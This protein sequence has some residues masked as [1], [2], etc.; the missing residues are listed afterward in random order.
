MFKNDPFWG[1]PRTPKWPVFDHFFSKIINSATENFQDPQKSWSFWGPP[2]MQKRPKPCQ[3]P[4]FAG[5]AR[6]LDPG[7][8]DD[9]PFWT[10]FW[11][12][13]ANTD[14][15]PHIIISNHQGEPLQYLIP[16]NTVTYLPK[17]LQKGVQ[18]W[19]K[20]RPKWPFF[21][22]KWITDYRTFSRISWK[23]GLRWCFPTWPDGSTPEIWPTKFA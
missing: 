4:F 18:K 17:G 20:N 3:K 2:K 11:P 22:Q 8:Q 21:G 9:G 6:F 13:P 7:V 1:T 10:P 14:P 23:K 15:Y 5:L 19:S 12:V 16:V